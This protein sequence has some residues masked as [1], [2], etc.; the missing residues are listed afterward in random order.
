MKKYCLFLLLTFLMLNSYGQNCDCAANFKWL[1]ETFEANDAGYDYVIKKKGLQ[2]YNYL[3][4]DILQRAQAT[5]NYTVCRDLMSEWLRFFRKFHLSVSLS[6]SITKTESAQYIRDFNQRLANLPKSTLDA[7]EKYFISDEKWS[8]YLSTLNSTSLEG[9][10]S[11]PPYTVGI[12]KKDNGYVGFVIDA[13][14]TPFKKG[15]LKLKIAKIGTGYVGTT[16]A[17]DFSPSNNVAA[18]YNHAGPNSLYVGSLS[19]KRLLPSYPDPPELSDYYKS[20][21]SV[22]LFNKLSNKTIY[23]KIPSF[24][25]NQKKK[26]DSIIAIHKD[27]LSSTENLIIDLRGNGGGSDNS[28]TALLPF[29]YTNPI[30]QVGVEYRST[31]LNNQ[32]L[33]SIA[34]NPAYD[35]NLR[36]FYSAG[37]D[38]LQKHMGEFVKL[39]KES[40][41]FD[42]IKTV[43]KK[44][45]KVAI[46]IDYY[47]G[48]SAEQFVVDARQSLR[49]KVFGK[50]TL[51]SLDM[52][53][54]TMTKSPGGDF[55]LRYSITK[56]LRIPEYQID[57][58]GVMPDVYLDATVPD[59]KWTTYVQRMLEN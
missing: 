16:Y 20:F 32:S 26:I 22:P 46:L 18:V 28:Y 27:L 54:M 38:T 59:Y 37:F 48:S 43:F 25:I 10:W 39:H 4:Q 47:T 3:N 11:S 53:N 34:Q 35:E 51:G 31:P 33:L 6:D 57:D 21:S 42:T 14:G 15:D 36:R 40:V 23:L 50:P 5:K 52:S 44:P 9:V 41:T 7:H 29:L 8:Q 1:K 45:L 24:N 55:I 58:V 13:P 56:S 12:I 19:F 30:R 49:V 2:S 17:R